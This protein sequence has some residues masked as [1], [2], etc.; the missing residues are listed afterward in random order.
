MDTLE[1]MR[2]ATRAKGKDPRVTK[3]MWVQPEVE[4]FAYGGVLTF[5]QTLSKTG[6]A[7]VWNDPD[8]GLYIRVADV[9]LVPAE[10]AT[11]FEQTFLRAAEMGF[12]LDA[13]VEFWSDIPVDIVHEMPSVHGKRIESSLMAAREIRRVN[14]EHHCRDI[15]MINRQAAYATIVGDRHAPKRVMK[16][17]V[18][19]LIPESRRTVRRWNQDV[20][21]SV[22][23]A[24]KHLYDKKQEQVHG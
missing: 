21:D 10:V 14:V 3:K 17:A 6:W 8:D 22:G 9:L 7:Q 12:L 16:A 19:R 20:T 11:G 2:A 5:D 4:D 15:H 13:V 23:L 1:E 18:E 24:L